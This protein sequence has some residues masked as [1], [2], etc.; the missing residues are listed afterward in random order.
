MNAEQAGDVLGQAIQ[1]ATREDFEITG[2][3][4]VG[5]GCIHRA[6]EVRGETAD[7]KKSYFAK[8]NDAEKKNL[9]EAE[10][11]GLAAIA[12]AGKVRVPGVVTSG[13]DGDEAWLVLEWLKLVPLDAQ[14]GGE[15]GLALAAQHRCR[16]RNSAGHATTSS[17][18]ARK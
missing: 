7:G 11:D 9:F 14:S 6:V 18:P 13:D 16:K 15:L 17:A 10:K 8:L 1:D 2:I 5:G 3:D 12:G 4:A